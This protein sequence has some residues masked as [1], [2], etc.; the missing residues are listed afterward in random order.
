MLPLQAMP[1]VRPNGAQRD[2]E[3]G[4]ESL[5]CH[6]E[7]PFL[8]RDRKGA[9]P[10]DLL[11]E[12]VNGIQSIFDFYGPEGLGDPISKGESDQQS[13]AIRK[14][15]LSPELPGMLETIRALSHEYGV[16]CSLGH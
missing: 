8:S 16:I 7:G 13:A 3:L 2:P 12:P 14:I 9:H 5:G 6:C 1:V 15:T 10:P 11:L 4:A